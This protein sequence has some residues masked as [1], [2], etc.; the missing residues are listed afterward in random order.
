[1]VTRRVTKTP[2]ACQVVEATPSVR[3]GLR[4]RLELLLPVLR[5]TGLHLPLGPPP[6]GFESV[7]C[8][9]AAAAFSWLLPL[10][11]IASSGAAQ[12]AV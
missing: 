8:G 6:S 10:R 7:A 3:E 1:M 12:R 5:N 2:T 9:R 4:S 11:C